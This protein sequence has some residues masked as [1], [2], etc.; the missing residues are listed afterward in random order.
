[1]QYRLST[2][3]LIFFMV[4]ASL[5][6]FG[7]WGIYIAAVL[8]IAALCLNRAKILGFGIMGAVFIIFIGSICAGLLTPAKATSREAG[9]RVRC[10]INLKQ[11][12]LALH[13]YHDTNKHF[14]PAN[15]CDKDGKPLF[16]WRVEILP[17]LEHG[18]IYDSLKKDEP[19]NSPHNA[20]ILNYKLPEFVCPRDTNKNDLS[21]SYIAIIGPGTA[22]REDG[23]VKLS[24]LPD[25]GKH[26]VMAVEVAD[27]GVH[28]VEP[29]DLT[30][31]EALEGL[32][33]GK[34]LRISSAHPSAINILFA[35]GSVQSLPSKMPISVWQIILAGD[36]IDLD[37]IRDSY[38]ESAPD[39][40]DI[41]IYTP[42]PLPYEPGK[43]KIILG[44]VVWLLSIVLLFSRAIKSRPKPAKI[45]I[46]QD[47]V[48]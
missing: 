8:S 9:I 11:I 24:D 23:P 38:D 5:A 34:G 27:S 31:E 30:V 15:T 2:L 40:V 44:A 42:Y 16:S 10:L 35:D 14:P 17:M 20:K 41:S 37:Y 39:M 32:K 36:A 12:G 43:W 45:E 18:H 6:L 4:A 26:T 29:R 25:G 1:M 28:W 19:W 7:V 3:F 21:T 48:G 33:T 46:A 47:V 22:W 13:H